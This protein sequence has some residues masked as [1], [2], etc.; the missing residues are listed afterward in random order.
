VLADRQNLELRVKAAALPASLLPIPEE[1]TLKVEPVDLTPLAPFLPKGVGLQGGRVEADLKAILGAAVPGG[2]GPTRL[3]GG[4]K[5]SG[6]A[7]V[8]QQGD[9]RIDA[10]LDADLSADAGAGDLSIQRLLLKVGR[11]ELA[12]HGRATGLR[13]GAPRI[14]DLEIT[15]HDLDPAAILSLWPPA[16][17]QLG[18]VV[19]AGPVG[20]SLRGGG[21]ADA[22]RLELKLD[23]TPVRLEVPHQ[24]QKAAGGTL[25]LTAVADAEQGGDRVRFEASV[26]LGGVD[27]RPGG[28]VAKKPGD[29]LAV[30]LVGNYRRAGDELQLVLSELALNLLGGPLTGKGQVELAGTGAAHTARFD[31]ELSGERLD[32]DRLLLSSSPQKRA[33]QPAERKA[34]GGASTPA[35]QN[36]GAG[37]WAGLS[38]EARLRLGVLKAKGA[39]ARNVAARVTVRDDAVT[40]ELAHLDAFGGSVDAAGTSAHLVRPD[41]PF[42]A[43]VHLKGIDSE[44]AAA[45]FSKKRVLSGTLDADLELSGVGTDQARMEKT[46]QGTLQG[47]LRKG[48]FHGK[49][50]IG[51]ALG[52]LAD[53]LPFAKK[54]AEGGETSLGEDLPFAFH[55]ADGEAKLDKPLQVQTGQGVVEL[56]GGVGL[57]GTLNMPTRVALSPEAVGKLTG[58]KVKPE[59]PIPVT[60]KLVGPTSSPGIEGLSVDAAARSIA[61]RAAKSAVTDEAKRLE[62]SVKDRLKGLFGK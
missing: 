27:L 8:G 30:K 54:L 14:E 41:G 29:P 50:L 9:R 47:H 7:F 22:Q 48:V 61:A 4:F 6:L 12:G 19:L 18:G 38:G 28:S 62:S 16:T 24:L 52:S 33:A 53:K 51:A 40:L 3:L 11:G 44:Q 13:G 17:K 46:A 34:E 56:G 36:G 2:H 55:I 20:L 23:L 49:D 43:Q 26:D 21:G 57:D 45:L 32:L 15:S 60:F 5:A 39:E 10:S 25:V 1:L 42:K 59:A 35:A 31:A 58:G 37:A